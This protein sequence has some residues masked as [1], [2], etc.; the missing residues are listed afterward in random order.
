MQY[1]HL[2]SPIRIG[3]MEVKNRFVVPAMGTNLANHDGTVSERLIDYWTARAAGGW[4]LL[5]VEVTAIDP[6]GKAGPIQLGLWDDGFIEGFRKLTA[7]AH[8]HGA[9]IAVQLHHAGR[10]TFSMAIGAQPVAPSPVPCPICRDLPRE[11]SAD[12]VYALINQFGQAAERAREAGFDA[13]EIHGAHGYLVAQFMSGYANK[14]VDE[15]GGGFD[16]LMR[17]P[18][19]IVKNIRRRVGDDFPVIF[20]ISAEERV[21]GGRTLNESVMAARV[22]EEAGVDAL[23]ISVGVYASS[24]YI[25]APPALPPGHLL[26]AAAE[27]KKSVSIPLITVGRINHPLLAEDAIATGKTDLLAWGRQSL[28]DPELPQKVAEGRLKDAAP[29]IAC[30]QGCIEYVMKLKTVSCLVNPFC[31]REGELKLEPAAESKKVV[32]VG[33][34]PAG[35]EAAWVAAARGH[36]VVLFEKEALPGGQFKTAAVPPAKQELL[37]VI[38]YY[39]RMGEKYGVE[40]RLGIEAT[41]EIVLAEKPAAVIIATGGEPLVPEIKGIEGSDAVSAAD[42]LRGRSKA[43]S[44]VLIIGGGMVGCETADFLAERGHKVT[45]VEALPKIARDVEQAV[46]YFL[47]QRLKS[48][49]VRIETGATVKEITAGGVIFERDGQETELSGYK[50]I[51]LALGVSPVNGLRDQLEG[52]APTLLVIGDAHSPGK[53]ID[54]ITRGAEAAL[55]L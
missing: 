55:Q 21:P 20:R 23:N 38:E 30:T 18:V 11:L 27:L 37:K 29:C 4:G 48:H 2:F 35:L 52:K 47:L 8:Q 25:Q 26:P 51:V 45:I 36:R 41:A 53:A 28:A 3:G 6:L 19:E 32:V 9:K 39:R 15:F 43:G 31:G 54:A 17:F 42:L 13:V 50:T 10:Q 7:T 5:I 46:K 16:N 24:Q 14:R 49:G 44:R 34:G 12:E 40:F 1:S 33:G 22:L